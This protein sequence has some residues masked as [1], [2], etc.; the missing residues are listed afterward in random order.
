M[1]PSLGMLGIYRFEHLQIRLQQV[2]NRSFIKKNDSSRKDKANLR[3]TLTN[4]FITT[5]VV[6]F[7]DPSMRELVKRIL[8]LCSNYSI[9]TRFMEGIKHHI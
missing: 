9:V 1:E 5:V 6:I 2:Y 4:K 3:R 8:P 7:S